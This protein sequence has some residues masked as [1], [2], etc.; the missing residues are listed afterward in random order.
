MNASRPETNKT[1]AALILAAGQGTR[2]GRV[3]KCLIHLDH[4]PII[5]RQIDAFKLAGINDITVV[6]GFYHEQIETVLSVEP[7]LHIVRNIAPEQG[8]QSSVRLGLARMRDDPD[9]VLIALADQP[10]INEQDLQELVCA[11]LSRP[12]STEIIYPVVDGQRG[13]PV[14][15]SAA[16]V[17]EFLRNEA[18]VTCRKFIDTHESRVYKYSTQNDH[19]VADLDTQDD[20]KTLAERTGLSV[21]F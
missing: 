8:Q 1:I 21:K 16:S 5:L 2:M 4:Q 3:P 14:L 18:E 9:V 6:T 13:N 19:F 11:Y 7:T 12:V 20:L 10:L 15:M 17:K